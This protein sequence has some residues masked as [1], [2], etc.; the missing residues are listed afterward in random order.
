MD[1][2]INLNVHNFHIW[3]NRQRQRFET[4]RFDTNNDCNVHCVYCHVPRSKDLIDL[5]QFRAFL[6]DKVE[7]TN[8]FQ[9][10]CQMEPT[11]DKRL[12][13]FMQA[14]AD[15]PARPRT[16][17]RLQTNGI[18]LH[19]HDHEKMCEAGLNYLAV[20]MDS[21]D[22]EL[23]KKL[24]GGTSLSKVYKNVREFHRKCPTIRV[25]F[26]TTITSANIGVIDDLVEAGLESGVAVFNLRQ[27]GYQPDNPI[28][29]HSLMR[30]LIVSNAAFDAMADRVK[31]KYKI[32]RF[33]IQ[34]AEV[35]KEGALTVR[36]ASSLP[37]TETEL[38]RLI[39][40]GL[41]R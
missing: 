4:I 19:R 30:E 24:R 2:T 9:F 37:R 39:D 41:S 18:L 21:V 29:D 12:V 28:V 38:I 32:A 8:I 22:S 26:I 34:G 31:N 16:I 13:S 23:V 27:V 1:V 14:V 15:S 11:I 3:Q 40:A 10:G 5:D 6:G 36:A 33:Y 17:F 25:G 20:S 7:S 35:L